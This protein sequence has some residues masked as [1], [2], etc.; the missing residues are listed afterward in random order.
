MTRGPGSTRFVSK[1]DGSISIIRWNDPSWETE[2]MSHYDTNPSIIA[3]KLREAYYV[4]L[5]ERLAMQEQANKVF[6]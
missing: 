2:F 4:G 1:P 5:N 6:R 3:A